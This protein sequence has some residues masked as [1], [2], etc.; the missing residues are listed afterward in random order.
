MGDRFSD[1][2]YLRYQYGDAEKVR[3]RQES[4]RCYS[5]RPNDAFFAWVVGHLAPRSGTSV[6]DVGCGPGIYHPLLAAQ[7][8]RVLAVDL[9]A[10]MVQATRHRAARERLAVWTMQADAQA[11]PLRDASCDR[12]LAAHMLYHVPDRLAALRELRRVTR[13]GGRVVLVTGAGDTGGASRLRTLHA[14]A[15]RELGYTP[16]GGPVSFTLDHLD[17]VRAVFPGAERHVFRNAFAFPTAEAALAYYA[18]GMVDG[19][20]ERAPDGSHRARLLALVGARLR[21]VIAREG[22]FR[23]AKDNGCFVAAV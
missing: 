12:A 6:A 4:H 21:A 23:D 13:P 1:P 18:S 20:H 17:L 16:E 22:V 8:A 7:G 10:G 3:I 15:A 2:D 14:E 19:I 9:S 11:L 5:E